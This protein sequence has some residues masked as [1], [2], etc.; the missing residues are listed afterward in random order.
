MA[1]APARL[2]PLW[3]ETA[4]DKLRIAYRYPSD[5]TAVGISDLPVRRDS[6]TGWLARLHRPSETH[7]QRE[8]ERRRDGWSTG[9]SGR[10]VHVAIRH[11]PPTMPGYG[12]S[13]LSLCLG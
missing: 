12:A 5:P 6:D 10:F 13:E 4:G 11:P 7:S 2:L 1:P 8:P 9:P 3:S